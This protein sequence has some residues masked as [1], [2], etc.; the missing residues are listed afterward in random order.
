MR[1][2]S[3]AVRNSD[4]NYS[5]RSFD[6][7]IHLRLT[8]PRAHSRRF[9]VRSREPRNILR[10]PKPKP[11]HLNRLALIHHIVIDTGAADLRPKR[12]QGRMPRRC[13]CI[14]GGGAGGG[15]G[16]TDPPIG[17]L[18]GR[19]PFQRVPSVRRVVR[20]HPV[21]PFGGKPSA[22][23][24]VDGGVTL[25]DNVPPSPQ[26]RAP[27]RLLDGRQPALRY[28]RIRRPAGIGDA[29]GRALQNDRIAR[30]TVRRQKDERVQPHAITHRHIGLET[31]RPGFRIDMV[32][33]SFCLTAVSLSMT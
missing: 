25:T 23:V 3:T 20:I 21:F 29:I 1:R 26:N 6:R 2:R 32:G 18:L 11:F 17:P 12:L 8:E 5:L 33:H 30:P 14:G 31:A 7:R 22:R 10:H 24:L 13:C 19:Y 27:K 28:I 4:S 15:T 16:H 9:T